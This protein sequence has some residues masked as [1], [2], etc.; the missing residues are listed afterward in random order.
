[1]A[2]ISPGHKEAIAAMKEALEQQT[3]VNSMIMQITAEQVPQKS[4]Y[5][6]AK[7]SS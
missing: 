6:A 1:M 5:A 7:Q 4:A 2:E 3:L